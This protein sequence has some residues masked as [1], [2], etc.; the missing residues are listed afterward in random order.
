MPHTLLSI[1][2][3]IDHECQLP[4]LKQEVDVSNDLQCILHS[5]EYT[6]FL[7]TL[8]TFNIYPKALWTG[9]FMKIPLD[10]SPAIRSLKSRIVKIKTE[11]SAK[12]EGIPWGLG[13]NKEP[14]RK[15][16]YSEGPSTWNWST[17]APVWPQER[18]PSWSS[19]VGIQLRQHEHSGGS[20]LYTYITA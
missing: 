1:L 8:P 20:L 6:G 13:E 11:E 9:S 2:A 10:K 5:S 19:Y 17:H 15:N 16:K 18:G 4:G 3:L 14:G 12:A 7:T